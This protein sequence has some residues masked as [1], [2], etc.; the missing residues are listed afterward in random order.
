MLQVSLLCLVLPRAVQRFENGR[1]V[2]CAIDLMFAIVLLVMQVFIGRSAEQIAAVIS[3]DADC[4]AQGLRSGA[5]NPVVTHYPDHAA[6]VQAALRQ[7]KLLAP[8]SGDCTAQAD[9]EQH[10]P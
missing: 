10:D 2:L 1:A 9:Y 4:Y 3:R 7:Q 6:K 8:R 5:V